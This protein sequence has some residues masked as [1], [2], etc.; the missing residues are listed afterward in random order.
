MDNIIEQRLKHS[1]DYG[2]ACL[3]EEAQAI[4]DIVPEME[5]D[6]DL[7]FVDGAKAQNHNF[8]FLADRRVRPGTAAASRTGKIVMPS[9]IRNCTGP[10]A[11]SPMGI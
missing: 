7:I 2:K 9:A 3:R 8:F 10:Y 4:L 1:L 5:M 11:S 6:F